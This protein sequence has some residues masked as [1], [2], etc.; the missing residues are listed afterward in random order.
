MFNS[1][2][3]SSNIYRATLKFIRAVNLRL[4]NRNNHAVSFL[5]H[6][7]HSMPFQL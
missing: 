1:I 4:Q 2:I 7:S 5:G 6:L 3:H